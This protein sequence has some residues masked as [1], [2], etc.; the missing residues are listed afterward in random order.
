MDLGHASYSSL[1]RWHRMHSTHLHHFHYVGELEPHATPRAADQEKSSMR[2][3]QLAAIRVSSPVMRPAI[4]RI[5][6]T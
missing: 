5:G 3:A 4:S 6:R 2:P 1:L